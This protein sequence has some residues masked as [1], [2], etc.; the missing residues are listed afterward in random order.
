MRAVAREHRVPVL[1]LGRL[2]CV[3]VY[4][5]ILEPGLIRVGDSVAQD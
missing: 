3:G 4:L 5:D 1:T 2:S